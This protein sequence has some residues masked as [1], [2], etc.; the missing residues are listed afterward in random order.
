MEILYAWKR[1]RSNKTV[2]NKRAIEFNE[3]RVHNIVGF[4]LLLL[5]FFVKEEKGKITYISNE[6]NVRSNDA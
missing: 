4:F 3:S 5:F 1:F 6:L 2:S